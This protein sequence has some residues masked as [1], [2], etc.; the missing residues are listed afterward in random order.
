MN[1]KNTIGLAALFTILLGTSTHSFAD[2]INDV[3]ENKA[4]SPH[5]NDVG[6]NTNTKVGQ[7]SWYGPGFHGRKTASGERYNM[8]AFS[9]AHRTLPFGTKLKITC[10]S[11]GKSV[12]VKVND[13]GPFHGN[14]VLDLSYGAA[15]A[16][17]TTQKGV[18][19][20]KYEILN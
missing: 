7:A 12:I 6:K 13:R 17:G 8:N 19:K 5:V 15:K 20:V 14:R 1:F 9:A 10:T 16:L 11:T 3:L 2:S 4:P 18:S